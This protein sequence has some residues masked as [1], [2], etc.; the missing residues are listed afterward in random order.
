MGGGRSGRE[1]RD[2]K[3]RI[4]RGRGGVIRGGGQGRGGRERKSKETDN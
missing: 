3:E 2:G 1:K 4:R